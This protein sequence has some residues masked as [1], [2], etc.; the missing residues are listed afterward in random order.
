MTF[1]EKL[2]EE[3]QKS[4]RIHQDTGSGQLPTT[5]GG[6]GNL[7][8]AGGSEGADKYPDVQGTTA[9]T[10]KESSRQ[11]DTVKQSTK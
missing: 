8:A 3:H 4:K 6:A 2:K 5:R 11:S 1:M 9:E 7:S 10:S